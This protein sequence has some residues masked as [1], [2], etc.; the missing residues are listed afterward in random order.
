MARIPP[1]GVEHVDVSALL[2][3]VAALR[4]EVRTFASARGEIADIRATL[5]A[6]GA[7]SPSDNNM[8]EPPA[9][10]FDAV[11]PV[12]SSPVCSQSVTTLA[13]ALHSTGMAASDAQSFAA[14]ATALK[15]SGMTEKP[16]PTQQQLDCAHKAE[17]ETSCWSLI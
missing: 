12:T 3:E 17:T 10:S 2:H 14:L 8:A 13:S 7:S 9:S 16:Q 1:V 4:A 6:L 15:V 11:T 5:Q